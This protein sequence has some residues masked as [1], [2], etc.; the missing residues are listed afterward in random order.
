MAD[1]QHELGDVATSFE[2]R[3]ISFEMLL[4]HRYYWRSSVGQV[5]SQGYA[6]NAVSSWRF[7][8]G[9]PMRTTPTASSDF[10]GAT[11]SYVDNV[12]WVATG[13]DGR[14]GGLFYFYMNSSTARINVYH[15]SGANDYIALSAEL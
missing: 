1:V 4:C 13:S 14:N 15:T 2:D 11:N 7:G 8:P 5:N 3:P 6:D 9:V 12:T 10:T